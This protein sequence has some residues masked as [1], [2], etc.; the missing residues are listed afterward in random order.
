MPNRVGRS[1]MTTELYACLYAKEFPAQAILRLRNE[2]REKPCVVM[3]GEPPS[4]RVCSLNRRARH[5]GLHYGM[6]KVE[7]DTFAGPV[8]LMRSIP[9]EARTKA[10]LYE[11]GGAF[12]PRIEDRSADRDFLC[13]VDIAG[14][15][16]LFGPPEILARSLLERVRSLGISARVVIASNFHAAACLAKSPSTGLSVLLIP[17]GEEAAALA[18]LPLSVLPLTDAQAETF[19]LWGIRTLGMLASLP[20]NDLIARMG[21]E[22]KSLRQLAR[23][24]FPHLFQPTGSAFTLEEQIEL[25]TPVEFLDALLFVVSVLLDQLVL[26]VSARILALASVTLTLKLDGGD[27]YTRSVRPA[28][29]SNDKQLWIKLIHLDLEAHPPQA[30]ILSV[31]LHA[32]PGSTSKL[33]LGLFSPQLPEASRLDVTLARIRPV[34]GDDN[35]GRAVLQ[36]THAPEAFRVEPFTVPRGDST[37]TIPSEPRATIRQLRPPEAISVTLDNMRPVMFF[38]RERRYGVEHAYGPWL[39]GGEWW[40][41]TLWKMEQWDLVARAQDDSILC[42]CTIRDPMQ[43][44]WQMVALYD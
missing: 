22:S 27:A 43:Y 1:K 7:V 23:G 13:C 42:C 41:Q 34:V 25:D 28:M 10:I 37:V 36:D 32:E 39:A 15:K 20:E 19:A 17:K 3:E 29:P 6:T 18:P 5:L 12:S 2:L 8:I 24:E 26:R 11:C 40:N 30:P 31:A 38:F 33:Q 21:Q 16:S 9:S 35:V 14:M 4:Q 44:R